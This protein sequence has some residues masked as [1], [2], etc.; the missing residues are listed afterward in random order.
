[1]NSENMPI[2]KPG[3]KENREDFISRCISRLHDLDPNR[4]DKQIVAI[5]HEAWRDKKMDDI[6]EKTRGEGQGQGGERQ[7]DGGAD[8]CK[9]PKCGYKAKHTKGKPCGKCPKCG[10][11]MKGANKKPLTPAEEKGKSIDPVKC[12]VYEYFNHKA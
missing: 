1:M 3:K 9:C 7:G 5:C 11:Q 2:P 12:I 4:P 10:T 8:I 6:M